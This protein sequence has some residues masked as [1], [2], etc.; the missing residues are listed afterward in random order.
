M[1]E[2]A[3]LDPEGYI[4]G[5]DNTRADISVACGSGYRP[6]DRAAFYKVVGR[7]SI[8]YAI[9]GNALQSRT[10]KITNHHNQA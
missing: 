6:L 2:P 5:Y 1:Q 4:C 10:R 7:T 9:V 3:P 8:I